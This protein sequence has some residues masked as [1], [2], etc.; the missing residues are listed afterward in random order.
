MIGTYPRRGKYGLL[1]AFRGMA[2][3]T[4]QT[5]RTRVTDPVRAQSATRAQIGFRK[6]RRP[7]HREKKAPRLRHVRAG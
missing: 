2:R 3:G 4:T 6:C 1:D 7:Q 5:K